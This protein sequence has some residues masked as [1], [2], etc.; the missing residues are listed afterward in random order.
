MKN[1]DKNMNGFDSESLSSTI[2]NHDCKCQ[3]S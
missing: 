1:C 2:P 3:I